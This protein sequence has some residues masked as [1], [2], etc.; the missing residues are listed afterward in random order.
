MLPKVYKPASERVF[1]WR[2]WI[3]CWLHQ[4]QIFLFFSH[5]FFISDLKMI[6][7]IIISTIKFLILVNREGKEMNSKNYEI[8]LNGIEHNDL[9][10][11]KDLIE[12]N[13]HIFEPYFLS[14]Y[15]G[16]AQYSII[17]GSFE[18]IEIGVG[19]FECSMGINYYAGCRNLNNN[20]EDQN[21]FEYEIKDGKIH[22]EIDETIWDVR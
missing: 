19:F 21:M 1:L 11:I 5:S 18:V 9:D 16:D 14:G 17:D 22:I 20:H 7:D 3:R 4:F 12:S 2:K 13:S 8:S 10:A 6:F 15:G